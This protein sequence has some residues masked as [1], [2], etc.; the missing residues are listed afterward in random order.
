MCP[1]PHLGRQ[2]HKRHKFLEVS[3]LEGSVKK[4]E[5]RDHF[6]EPP[7]LYDTFLFTLQTLNIPSMVRPL[8]N[9][10]AQ[11]PLK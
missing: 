9:G 7:S 3:L 2:G 4:G 1:H 5:P 10:L 8:R 11:F 6:Q